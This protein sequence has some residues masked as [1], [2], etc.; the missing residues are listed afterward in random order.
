VPSFEAVAESLKAFFTTTTY[1]A[2]AFEVVIHA[3]VQALCELE[4][5]DGTLVPLSQMRSA[6]KKHGNVGDIEIM[7]DDLIVVSWD[8][9]YG[10]PYLRDELEELN[11]KLYSHPSVEIAGFITNCAI[12]R[13]SDILGRVIEI[14]DI[15]ECEILLLSF[16]EWIEQHT[17]GLGGP[18]LSE[19]ANRWLI[20]VVESFGQKR[21]RLAPIDEPC[22][23]WIS[24]LAKVIGALSAPD[25]RR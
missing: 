17:D 15:H 1:S 21:P 6:N 20:A 10:K 16:D 7:H 12:D 13:T 2:R 23:D 25:G 8:A 5:V 18:G 11:D 9:K 22:D 14:S 4:L 24:D 3:F 19:L